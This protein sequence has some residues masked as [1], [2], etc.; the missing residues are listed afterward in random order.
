MYLITLIL[1]IA[2]FLTNSKKFK[3][4]TTEKKNV[5]FFKNPYLNN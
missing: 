3:N 1:I 4:K 2:V 5:E